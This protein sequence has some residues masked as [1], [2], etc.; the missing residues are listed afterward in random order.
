M[1]AIKV[2]N[3]YAVVIDNWYTSQEYEAIFNECRFIVDYG[4]DP[5]DQHAGSAK[6]PNGTLLK[7]NRSIFIDDLFREW[8]KSVINSLSYKKYN[9]EFI[10]QLVTIDPIYS[11]LFDTNQHSCLVSYYEDS[12]YYK[13]HYDTAAFTLLT[14]VYDDPKSFTGG[15]LYLR[16]HRDKSII[17][18][19]IECISNRAVIFPSYMLHEVT[20]INMESQYRNQKK[21]R[22]TI[23]QFSHLGMANK[24]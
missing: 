14:W 18:A 20:Q 12:G 15:D 13:P 19:N 16:P 3:N 5:S 7:N 10:N 9:E 8:N 23:S 21:G 22:F 11:A 24:G 6:S 17:E 4:R 2:N 1:E